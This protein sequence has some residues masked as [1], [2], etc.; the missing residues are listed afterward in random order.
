MNAVHGR[1]IKFLIPRVQVI[2]IDSAV[3]GTLSPPPHVMMP[4]EYERCLL[5]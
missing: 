2:V 3:F 1:S 4:D 5:Y